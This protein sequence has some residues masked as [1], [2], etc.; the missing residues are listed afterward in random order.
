MRGAKVVLTMFVIGVLFGC[1]KQK[2]PIDAAGQAMANGGPSMGQVDI[3]FRGLV[4][5]VFI[6]TGAYVESVFL[7][8]SGD[9]H[10]PL[11]SISTEWVDDTNATDP[12]LTASAGGD[13][14]VAIWG[15]KESS[16]DPSNVQDQTLTYDAGK[17]D[18]ANPDYNLIR[19]VPSMD[20]IFG[21]KQEVDKNRIDTAEALGEWHVGAL[22]P[23]FDRPDYKTDKWNIGSRKAT[24]L[25]DGLRLRL[26]LKDAGLPLTLKL[27]LKR[28]GTEEVIQVKGGGTILMSAYPTTL[29]KTGDDLEHFHHFYSLIKNGASTPPAAHAP[30]PYP[31]RC[32]PCLFLPEVDPQ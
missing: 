17:V 18:T 5:F 16:I 13:A 32:A 30:T 23:V 21:A 1:P 7:S 26:T 4:A 11:C 15:F 24:P 19:W 27:R 20:D 10:T 8:P 25:A 6:K 14:G 22:A 28:N 2:P 3:E 12:D 31:A 9:D 29:P